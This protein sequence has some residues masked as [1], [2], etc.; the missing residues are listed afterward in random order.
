MASRNELLKELQKLITTPKEVVSSKYLAAAGNYDAADVLSDS[1]TAANATTFQFDVGESGVIEKAMVLT[2]ETAE[3]FRVHLK[4]Y[5][6]KPTCILTD[7][8]KN[9]GVLLADVPYYIGPIDFM[10]LEEIGDVGHS[11]ATVTPSTVGNLPL[12]YVCPGGIAYG[13]A[14]TRDATTTESV[15]MSLIFKLQIKTTKFYKFEGSN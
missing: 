7:N 9:T 12:S 1:A 6:R 2:S 4:L 3:T 14:V 11:E 15:G 5:S 8:V 13:V 10:A